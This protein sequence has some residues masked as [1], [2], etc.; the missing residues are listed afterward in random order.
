MTAP[1]AMALGGFAFEAIGF[2]FN[3]ISKNTNTP[4]VDVPVAQ[5]LNK[6]QWT[7]PTSVDVTI[8]GVL[9]PEEFGGETQL[10]GI[11]AT[12][13]RGIPMTLVS[14]DM[15]RGDIHG[16]YTVQSVK[17]DGTHYTIAAAAR[18]KA[19]TIQLKKYGD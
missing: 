7:G 3:D 5:T 11:A 13:G 19:Y 10:N 9:F 2:G 6:Q 12:A 4:W 15:A 14:G 17:E 18:R 8:K 1:V 16:L